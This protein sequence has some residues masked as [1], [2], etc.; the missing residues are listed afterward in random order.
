M[1]G[2][3][4][5][6]LALLLTAGSDPLSTLLPA[7]GTAPGWQRKGQE[8]LFD[9]AALYRHIN[10][11]AELY[12]QLGF[13]RLAVQDYAS[14]ANE[15]RVEIYKMND[16]SG[17]VAVFAETAK[18]LATQTHYGMGCILDDYQILFHRG[19]FC[20][21]LT[22]YE[23]GPETWAAMTAMAAKIDTA[24]IASCP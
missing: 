10:G 21:S 1:T 15:I 22:T 24:L 20:V 17:A 9:G 5:W 4:I 7:D 2:R 12:L 6:A 8:R 23:P 13:D 3:L 14:D 19:A 16:A 11:G 18:G